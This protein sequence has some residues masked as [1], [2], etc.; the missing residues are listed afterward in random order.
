M[1]YYRKNELQISFY[2]KLSIRLLAPMS[3]H[4]TYLVLSIKIISS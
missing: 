2:I 3:V 1:F 4:R